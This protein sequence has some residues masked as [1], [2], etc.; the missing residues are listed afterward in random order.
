MWRPL[1]P[2]A[3]RRWRRCRTV[4]TARG[5]T[6]QSASRRET[7][8]QGAQ[9]QCESEEDEG[10]SPSLLCPCL[11]PLSRLCIALLCP[12]KEETEALSSFVRAGLPE[13]RASAG[14]HLLFFVSISSCLIPF[15]P[16]CLYGSVSPGRATW[17]R[18]ST[19]PAGAS[20]LPF[21]MCVV[22]WS[23]AASR[24]SLKPTCSPS[25]LT[26]LVHFTSL[27]VHC[28]VWRRGRGKVRER[29]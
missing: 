11:I 17:S 15:T 21:K 13:K 29:D 28:Q 25:R 20:S 18:R 19:W 22:A 7:H 10:R 9:R 8:S 27:A 5:S 23:P 24:I 12:P 4:S 16:A 26:R 3:R 14:A 1:R 6:P 2:C